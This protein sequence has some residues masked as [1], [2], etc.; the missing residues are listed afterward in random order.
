MPGYC[1][2]RIVGPGISWPS[3]EILKCRIDRPLPVCQL[4][5][6]LIGNMAENFQMA[7]IAC[8]V[9]ED[10]VTHFAGQ[11]EHVVKLEFFEMGL[12]DQPTRLREVLQESIDVCEADE[13]VD[14]VVLV[15]GLCGKGTEGLGTRRCKLVI[16]RAH[17]CVTL[18]LGSAKQY[19]DLHQN[20][21]G[22]YTYTPGWCRGG[23]TPGKAR[24]KRLKE[25]YT[26]QFD[27]ESAEYL[28]DV[29]KQAL[30]KYKTG[31]WVD[32]GLAPDREKLKDQARRDIANMG[33][34]FRD[35]TGDTRLLRD[36]VSGDW[37]EERFCVA[38]PGQVLTAT[39]DDRIII[40]EAPDES[41]P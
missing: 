15:Y 28:I 36:L 34:E 27:A 4:D 29:E 10:E 19:L 16:P 17:D 21:S 9:L 23:R 26:E 14:T 33:W 6:P 39:T 37:S 8:D 25:E 31:L 38:E 20:C 11:H 7:I 18:F 2:A 22:S 30:S 1:A 24:F 12:H 3:L 40:A 41:S 5:P 32:L 13:R 35:I